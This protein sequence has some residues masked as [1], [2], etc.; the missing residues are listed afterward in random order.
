MNNCLALC[1]CWQSWP[2]AS[3]ELQHLR[4]S[5]A[6]TFRLLVLFR[7]NQGWV[8]PP[9]SHW[10]QG[11]GGDGCG[12]QAR[13][14]LHY[15]SIYSHLTPCPCFQSQWVHGCPSTPRCVW[16]LPSPSS[17]ALGKVAPGGRWPP[18]QQQMEEAQPCHF[19]QFAGAQLPTHQPRVGRQCCIRARK[20]QPQLS[21]VFP[22][23]PKSQG[24]WCKPRSVWPRHRAGDWPWLVSSGQR[25]SGVTT[26]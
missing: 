7:R 8:S 22:S 15:F 23:P 12:G 25:P 11:E 17:R 5:S 20:S 18:E 16:S 19:L 21:C 9:A 3:L 14:V 13:L 24:L 26:N 1:C 4:T 2:G 10:P 6:S